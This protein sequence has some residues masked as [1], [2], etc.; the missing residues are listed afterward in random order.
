MT[1]VEHAYRLLST[2][3]VGPALVELERGASASDP[4]SLL[5]LGVWHLEG[6]YVAR[7]LR[8]SRDYFRR[9]GELGELTAENVYIAFLAN[10]VGGDADWSGAKARLERLAR[11]HAGAARQ[12]DLVENMALTSEGD[13]EVRPEGRQQSSS[14]DAWTFDDFFSAAECR[15]LIDAAAPLLQPS[16]IVDPTTGSLRPHPIRTSD[17]AAFPWVSED[18]VIGALNRRIAAASA[19][20]LGCGEPLQVLRYRPGQEYRPH[21]DALPSGDNQRILTMLVYLND[22]YT[23]GETLFTRTGLKFPGGAGNGL[24]FRNGEPG[25]AP[26]EQAE[27]AGLPVTAGEKYLA[28]RWIRE[29]PMI[30][31]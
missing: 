18:L 29:R 25:G 9:A 12:L 4:Q 23:G 22:D 14:P 2:G 24:L 8:R 11:S 20:E 1:A 31:T 3:G 26:D 13:P 30:A 21:L 10:G 28:S 6:R 16:V 15:Y 19:T 7:D 17:G 27:H 5:E